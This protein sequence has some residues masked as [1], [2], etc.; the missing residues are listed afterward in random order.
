MN[1]TIKLS[2]GLAFTDLYAR[3]GLVKLDEVFL[4]QLKD[5][6]PALHERLLAAR[7]TPPA[8]HDK[9]GSALIIYHR[10]P[11]SRN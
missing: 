5:S 10:L 7:Q 11:A 4:T 2:F 9:P 3:D 1:K 8:A 6:A